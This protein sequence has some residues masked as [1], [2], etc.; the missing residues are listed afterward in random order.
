MMNLVKKDKS[1]LY[2]EAEKARNELKL[3]SFE[4]SC[5]SHDIEL[6]DKYNRTFKKYVAISNQMAAEQE[7]KY[8]IKEKR[9]S[10]QESS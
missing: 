2:F 6:R 7:K 5:S 3:L 10:R 4:L 1:A 8:L 9:T